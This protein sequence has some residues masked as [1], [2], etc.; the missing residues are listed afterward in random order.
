MLADIATEFI[1]IRY[2]DQGRK[3]VTIQDISFA[4]MKATFIFDVL[5][6][7]PALVTGEKYWQYY[8][9]KIFRY[10]QI[11]RFFDQVDALMKK[12][13]AHFVIQAIFITNAYMLF[14]TFFILLILFHT[15]AS[16]WIYIG[17]EPGGWRSEFLFEH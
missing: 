15:L 2:I 6:C 11:P 9:F 1:T 16:I 4:Y 13:K 17:N 12:V 3:L 14:K 8:Y 7:I 10:L 5:A